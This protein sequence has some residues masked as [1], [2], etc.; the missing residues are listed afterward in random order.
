VTFELVS[1]LRALADDLRVDDQRTDDLPSTLAQVINVTGQTDGVRLA[2]LTTSC[3]PI[4]GRPR[5]H[6]L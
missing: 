2:E 3:G 5:A 6:W 4:P 1:I